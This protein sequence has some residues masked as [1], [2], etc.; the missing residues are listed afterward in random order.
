[1]FILK[2]EI[3]FDTAHYLSGYTGKCANLH[4]HRYRVSLPELKY[5]ITPI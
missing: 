2:S 3:Q 1:M 4:G 5:S